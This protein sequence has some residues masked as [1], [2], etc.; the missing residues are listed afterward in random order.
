MWFLLRMTFWLGLVLVLLPSVGSQPVSKSQVSVSEAFSA[1]KGAVTDVQNFCERQKETCAVGSQA[2]IALGQRVQAGAQML[3]EL[4]SEQFGSERVQNRAKGV[5][6]SS[7]RKATAAT[8]TGGSI[9][10]IA[11]LAV[12]QRLTHIVMGRPEECTW[13]HDCSCAIPFNRGVLNS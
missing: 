10:S 2:A 9:A 3:Y 13:T 7:A 12:H 5:R 1:T 4:L 8:I 11:Q 6:S